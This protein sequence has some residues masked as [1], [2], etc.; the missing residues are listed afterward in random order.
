MVYVQIPEETFRR[1]GMGGTR[2]VSVKF[3]VLWGFDIPGAEDLKI[4]LLTERVESLQLISR[5]K[6][7]A[8]E[9]TIGKP[10]DTYHLDLGMRITSKDIEVNGISDINTGDLCDITGYEKISYTEI[11]RSVTLPLYMR[12]LLPQELTRKTKETK[13]LY[14]YVTYCYTL[15]DPGLKLLNAFTQAVDFFTD[16]QLYYQYKRL[17][18]AES[19]HK[20]VNELIKRLKSQFEVKEEAKTKAETTLSKEL[21]EFWLEL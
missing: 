2:K 8:E 17:M 9:K 5:A 10:V 7:L 4:R 3:M 21:E 20:E 12:Y 14:G 13:K 18:K 6:T 11:K 1:V 16:L 19:R 15:R